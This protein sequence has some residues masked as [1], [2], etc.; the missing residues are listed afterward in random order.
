MAPDV[1][2]ARPRQRLR[3]QAE[4][5]EIERRLV[6]DVRPR[7]PVALDRGPVGLAERQRLDVRRRL[8]Q[9][10]LGRL[11]A[12]G[13]RHREREVVDL[14][15]RRH[16]LVPDQDPLDERRAGARQADDEDRPFDV[17]PG[18][19]AFEPGAIEGTDDRCDRLFVG[20]DL[21]GE[22]LAPRRRALRERR[23]GLGVFAEVLEFLGERIVQRD[24]RRARR[25]AGEHGAKRRHVVALGRLAANRRA[26][27]PGV[28]V[29]GRARDHF[30]EQ[31]FRFFHAP[32]RDQRARLGVGRLRV[33]GLERRDADRAGRR[34]LVLVEVAVE[35]REAAPGAAV[36]ARGA[37]DGGE[38]G[39]G[40]RDVARVHARLDLGE[41]RDRVRGIERER[42]PRGLQHAAVVAAL[43]ADA[44]EQQPALRALRM[45]HQEGVAGR[46][47]FREL[48]P[49]DQA[50]NATDVD[51]HV[52]AGWL[53]SHA[54]NSVE[55]TL[56][57]PRGRSPFPKVSGR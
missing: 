54:V 51:Q 56:A 7:M 50:V 24:R 38:R 5:E 21:V 52:H 23:K 28:G 20:L 12:R 44:R 15:D 17:E 19:R 46:A 48:A 29:V 34:L 45:A 49:L 55:G 39:A 22:H 35:F 47:R 4:V 3:D 36:R 32:D 8:D 13:A 30:V 6:D 37:L 27:V 14:A 42:V 40:A 41:A 57:S 43:L 26:V 16:L 53:V 33:V 10:F 1:H 18:S 31:R 25:T 2:D 9:L 11:R